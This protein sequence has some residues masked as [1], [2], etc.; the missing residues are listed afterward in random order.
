MHGKYKFSFLFEVSNFLLTF[1]F[2]LIGV[3]FLS[4]TVYLFFNIF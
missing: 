2:P 4:L 3:K 1:F